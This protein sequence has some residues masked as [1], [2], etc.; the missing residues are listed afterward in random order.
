[1]RLSAI[2]KTL[3]STT[4]NVVYYFF[5]IEVFLFITIVSGNHVFCISSSVM[6]AHPKL[7]LIMCNC[8]LNILRKYLNVTLIESSK[9][10]CLFHIF[11]FSWI[12]TAIDY[13][14]LHS[15]T[16]V[17]YFTFQLSTPPSQ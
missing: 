12:L 6:L 5:Y 2:C 4:H 1:M 7:M 3:F 15:T 17:V 16:H 9:V 14:I 11:I 10:E 13:F 8:F